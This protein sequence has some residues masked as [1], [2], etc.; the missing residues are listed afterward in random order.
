ME[1][2]LTKGFAVWPER[3]DK[4]LIYDIASNKSS[5]NYPAKGHDVDGKYYDKYVK[6]IKWANYWTQPL[7]DYSLIVD[8]RKVVDRLVAKFLIQ[9]TFYNVTVSVVTPD[10]TLIRPHVD[11][12][13][14]HKPW[15]NRVSRI[16]GI[17]IA[18]PMHEFVPEAGTTALLPNSYKK[19]W[20]IEKC[21]NGS[22]LDEFLVNAVQP[23]LHF[24]DILMWDARTLHS[25]MPNI[26][27]SNRYMLLMNYIEED[28]VS[29]V[30]EYEASLFS[31]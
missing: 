13:H 2:M 27:E 16:L 7:D 3:I 9:P 22:Y 6:G 23:K 15:N 1:Q 10:N 8:V 21:Y 28:I 14:R 18:I 31:E 4:S 5:F 29:K 17:Q 26:T 24:S 30:M 20:D 19:V 25:Q 11:T 12:P